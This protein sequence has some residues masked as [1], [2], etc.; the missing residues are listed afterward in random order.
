MIGKKLVLLFAFAL[1]ASP[2]LMAGKIA[3]DVW[4]GEDLPFD[5][6]KGAYIL[7][8]AVTGFS[9]PGIEGEPAT[10][11]DL[12]ED[13]VD[14]QSLEMVGAETGEAW[15]V[16][17]AAE[18][19]PAIELHDLLIPNENAVAYAKVFV[20]SD[21][22][23]GGELL[24]GSDDGVVVWFNGEQVFRTD[25]LRA[26]TLDQD[27]VKVRIREGR[28]TLLLKVMQAL[29]GWEFACRF[30]DNAGLSVGVEDD[31]DKAR[32]LPA[33]AEWFD[34][35]PRI[36]VG[37]YLQNIGPDSVTIMW[38]TDVPSGFLL[39]V[40][41]PSGDSWGY[42]RVEVVR[43]LHEIRV[44]GLEPDTRYGYRVWTFSS[45][46]G[47][48]GEETEPGY[49]FKTLPLERRGFTFVVYGDNRTNTEK[50][51]QVVRRILQDL[52]DRA[53]FVLSTGDLVGDGRDLGLWAREFFGPAEPL[54]SSLCLFPVLGNHEGNSKYYF[55]YFDLPEPERWY[56]F[57]ALNTHFIALDSNSDMSPG[58]DQYEWLEK[59]LAVHRDAAWKVAYLHHPP[60]TSGPHG[61]LRG[62][63][64]PS[65]NGIRQGRQHL[66]PLF[67]KE[68]VD[69]V[70]AG[71]DHCYERS[72][73]EGVVYVTTGGGGAPL[74][75][76]AHPEANPASE[77]FVSALHYV[78][79]TVDDETLSCVVRDVDGKVID[80][81][82]VRS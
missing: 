31:P 16:V 52:G 69:L 42:T 57:D 51:A 33:P 17:R 78:E 12:P 21:R 7:E 41:E 37:P 27:R 61:G 3:F 2:P 13:R 34:R 47:G 39:H 9:V 79:V 53:E 8:W 82:S 58:S 71:H 49:E 75:H 65:E 38:Q 72:S 63:G 32:A 25:A 6:P 81:Y 19:G 59:D 43:R 36:V 62:D 55:R 44:T 80:R 1:A 18:E 15:E 70:F 48:G 40:D 24:I 20:F 22:S 29:R 45:G 73:S 14:P 77:V 66:A 5:V 56:S 35:P 26:L 30:A 54:I 60:F 74:Y 50:H 76:Q 67:A 46:G 23:R 68:G 64:L 11:P 10:S 28:N 4:E